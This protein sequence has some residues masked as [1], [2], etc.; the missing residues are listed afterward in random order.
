MISTLF[1]GMPPD[2]ILAPLRG[3]PGVAGERRPERR[4]TD[5]A[6]GFVS[7]RRLVD[8]AQVRHSALRDTGSPNID[9]SFHALAAHLLQQFVDERAPEHVEK[10][11]SN[12]SIDP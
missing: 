10:T 12:P 1:A 5:T 4:G 11:G 9:P 6:L 2:A 3:R 8:S 7:S